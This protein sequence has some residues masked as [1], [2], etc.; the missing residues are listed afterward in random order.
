MK[1]KQNIVIIIVLTIVSIFSF[2]IG[3]KLSEKAN[4]K[5]RAE[6]SDTYTLFDSSFSNSKISQL[7]DLIEDE[8]VEDIEK[9]L[10]DSIEDE[11]IID[12]VSK[13]DPHSV[14]IPASDLEDV[15]SE[16]EGHFSGIGVQF[17]IQKDT[18][19]IVDVI[20]GG[21]SEKVGLLPGDRII[22]VNDT[23]F[24]G[25]DKVS[26]KKVMNKLRGKK[27]T[28]VTLG[29]KRLG[30]T[31][32]LSYEI[33]RGD[34]PI[35]SVTASYIIK[36]DIGFIGLNRN[37]GVKT[38][39]EFL[40]AIAQLKDKGANKFIIDLRNNGGGLMNVAIK[41]INEFLPKGQLIVYAEGKSYPR[42]DALA[43]GSGSCIKN[44]IVV[45]IDEFSA[46]ASE[47][48]AGAIQDNDRGTIIGRRSFGKGLVQSQIPFDD[49]SAVRL[50]IAKYFTPSGR[51]IQKPYKNGKGQEYEMD[52]INRFEHGEFYSKD[53]IHIADSLKFKTRNGRTVYGGG[54]IMPDIFVP[55]DTSE[56]SI[57]SNKVIN[58]GYTFQYAFEYTDQHRKE[59]SK[60]KTWKELDNY[61]S[62]QKLLNRFVLFAKKKGIKPNQKQIQISK[63]L[64]LNR[65]KGY[66]V[67]NMLDDNQY[68]QMINNKDEVVI[69]AIKKIKQ[70]NK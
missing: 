22:A 1:K 33:T 8:Y 49:G 56:Y 47:I 11:I 42:S 39:S 65:I 53:S 29:I 48:F 28:K 32:K 36:P 45:L 38:Y 70:K 58:H 57:Y 44:P 63:K 4:L 23:P 69:E 61:L 18:V 66:V 19:M 62:K 55:R 31:E 2:W 52:L 3:T 40:T 24:V 60:Y 12:I 67:R 14:Y 6:N 51:S 9:V 17:N 37:F 16:I 13:L 41:M 34:I 25:K 46:S 59:L 50:T 5:K 27:D 64:L 30:T 21:P 15:N 20:N 43:N 54:G 26:N 10:N 68:F 7:I 35:E